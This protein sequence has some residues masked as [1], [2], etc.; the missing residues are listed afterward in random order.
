MMTSLPILAA[1][2]TSDDGCAIGDSGVDDGTPTILGPAKLTVAELRSW[3]ASTGRAQ[4]ARLALPVADVAA[5]YL[6]EGDAEGVR[7]DLAFA[8]AIHETGYFTNP[9][10]AINN[11]AGIGHHD[12]ARSGQRFPD[13]VIGVRA[14]VQLLKKY[15]AGNDV[16]L[17]RP[18]VAPN[19]GARS[20]TWGGLAGTWATDPG[21]WT[22]ISSLYETMRR[23]RGDGGAEL[24]EAGIDGAASETADAR[25]A[26]GDLAFNG[27]YALP[28]ERRWYETHPEWFTRTHHDYP[29]VDIP[30]PTGTPLFAITSGVV[31]A[32]P[33]TGRCG[34]GAV[35]NGDDRAQYVYCHGLPGSAAVAIGDRV[36][37]GQ[38]LMTS[39]ST[40]NSTGPHLHLSIRIDGQ[41]RC[42]QPLLVAIAEGGDVDPHDL[43]A[44]GCAH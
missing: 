39:A 3:W 20:T 30:V 4:P 26:S 28:L 31:V 8:Q 17:A 36:T 33:T 9:D 6:S 38:Y 29:A 13:A 19:A 12:G 32:A 23:H 18:E 15:A 22:S 24:A 7:G 5:L 42:P 2:G 43:P 21:Y 27:A 1:G 44:A 35:F 37:A 34:I 25:C 16:R 41:N 10:T 14:H 40:G 11:F